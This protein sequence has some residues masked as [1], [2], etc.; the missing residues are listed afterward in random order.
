MLFPIYTTGA[1]NS[2]L[3][4]I[5]GNQLRILQETCQTDD[6]RKL[7]WR[8]HVFI[9]GSVAGFLQSFIACPLE[10]IK[11]RLQT[12]NCKYFKNEPFHSFFFLINELRLYFKYIFSSFIFYVYK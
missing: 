10:L 11:I 2:I 8:K 7:Y 1:L 12:Q 6:E 3:F 4:G 9:S 5:Y